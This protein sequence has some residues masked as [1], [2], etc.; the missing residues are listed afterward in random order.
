[1]GGV[2]TGR[3]KLWIPRG[4]SLDTVSTNEAGKSATKSVEQATESAA[5]K[6]GTT[7]TTVRER[8]SAAR[9]LSTGPRGVGRRAS[10]RRDQDLLGVIRWTQAIGST[11]EVALGKGSRR[12]VLRFSKACVT[13]QAE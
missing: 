11:G 1:M 3:V 12:N 10:S 8:P 2:S 13:G 5:R 7:A 9:A 4:W 6:L